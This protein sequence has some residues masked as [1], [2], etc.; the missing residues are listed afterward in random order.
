[1]TLKTM[2]LHH[3]SNYTTGEQIKKTG[4][5]S[6]FTQTILNWQDRA[7]MRYRLAELSE[8]NLSDMGL[9]QN[10]AMTEANKHFWQN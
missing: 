9:T 10:D 6:S 5:L 3:N 1:M 8:E 2:N 4:F 7:A